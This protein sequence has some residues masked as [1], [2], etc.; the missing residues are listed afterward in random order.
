MSNPENQI[1]SK[2]DRLNGYVVAILITAATVVVAYLLRDYLA[3][4]IFIVFAAPVAL[5]AWY[6]GRGPALFA[7]FLGVVAAILIFLDPVK[8]VVPRD[9]RDLIAIT[10]YALVSLIIVHVAGLFE[11]ARDEIARYAALLEDQAMQMQA[12]AAELEQQ[13]EEAQTLNEELEEANEVIRKSAAAQLAEAQSLAR[14]GSWEWDVAGNAITWSDEMYRLY[15]LDPDEGPIDFERYQSL[16]H[17][18]DRAHSQEIIGES[19]KTGEPFT[20][21]HRVLRAD[22]SD[23]VF[24]ARGKVVVDGHG[25]A[26]RMIG[27]GQDVTEARRAENALR[28]ASEYAAKQEAAESAAQHLNRVLSQAPVVIAVLSGPD[29]VFELANAKALD[30]LGNPSLIGKPLREA[31]PTMAGGQY[32]QLIEMVYKSGEPFIGR[33]MHAAIDPERGTGGYFN[34]V[35]QPLTNDT[36][37]YAILIVANEVTDLVTSRH[38]A[39]LAGQKHSAPVGPRA[40]SWRE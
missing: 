30:M 7:G 33:E 1:V 12:Q 31:I 25:K 5:A 14:V 11:K 4:S 2:P 6:G 34:F 18:D 21:H 27:T 23:R 10:I 22:G 35:F 15:G 19:M 32:E 37:V 28:N 36:G 29:H 8:G 24:Q 9:Y 39:E 26:V 38:A 3:K 13:T 40:I 16:V 17:P 20:F